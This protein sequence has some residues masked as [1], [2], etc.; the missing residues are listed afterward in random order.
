MIESTKLF[1]QQEMLR[2]QVRLEQVLFAAAAV[3]LLIVV[4]AFFSTALLGLGYIEF[5]IIYRIFDFLDGGNDYWSPSVMGLTSAIMI[6]GYHVM[7]EKHPRNLSVLF[8]D[9]VVKIL[10]PCYLI[11]AGLYIASM[12][13]SD[14]LGEVVGADLSLAIAELPE[15]GGNESWLDWLFSYVTSPFAVAAFSLGIG[16]LAIVNIFV[17]HF[18]LKHITR[19]IAA[20]FTRS[21]DARDAIK[22]YREIKRAQRNY[23]EA[24]LDAGDLA[25]KNDEYLIREIAAEVLG[26]IADAL[27]PHKIW[28]KDHEYRKAQSFEP[29]D[30]VDPK[31]VAKDVAKIEAITQDQII[32]AIMPKYLEDLR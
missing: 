22:N 31:Q 16:G 32:N 15:P 17:A 27:L 6:I 28:L 24:C 5:E 9:F 26:V 13:F 1:T 18:L 19:N 25:L 14:G 8:V 3:P 7:A 29:E 21:Q 23:T 12:L 4:S 10:V 30:P 11:G 20:V 2:F